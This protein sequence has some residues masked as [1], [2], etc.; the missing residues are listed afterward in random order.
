MAMDHHPLRTA[1]CA[2]LLT[3]HH[4]PLTLLLLLT[5]RAPVTC[6]VIPKLDSVRRTWYKLV[7][8]GGRMCYHAGHYFFLIRFK[9]SLNY[10][11][12][13]PKNLQYGEREK[14][15]IYSR[16]NS[17]IPIRYSSDPGNISPISR[18]HGQTCKTIHF[19]IMC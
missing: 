14:F 19:S 4:S 9:V 8:F 11:D 17:G 10:L 7:T 3:V 5:A 2:T 1:M 15:S 12:K 18:T 16:R 6:G 13:L